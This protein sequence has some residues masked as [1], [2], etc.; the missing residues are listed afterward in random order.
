MEKTTKEARHCEDA[1]QRRRSALPSVDLAPA[2]PTPFRAASDLR[3]AEADP[4]LFFDDERAAE[5][6]A[7]C[8]GCPAREACLAY[9]LGHEEFGVWGGATPAQRDA[10]RGRRLDGTPED[11]R[12]VSLIHERV[13]RG[14][15]MPDIAVAVGVNQRTLY[16]WLA[17]GG[18]S[19]AGGLADVA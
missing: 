18:R 16:R 3:C 8:A 14:D 12:V 4:D 10:L 17:D 5:A 1:G 11:R 6:I 15:L 2:L 13:A 7:L 9:A 19:S